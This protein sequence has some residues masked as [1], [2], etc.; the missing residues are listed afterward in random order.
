MKRELVVVAVVVALTAGCVGQQQAVDPART[1]RDAGAAMAKL[2]TVTATLKFTKEPITFQGFTLVGARTSVRL[3]ADSDTIYTVK[4]QDFTISLEVIISGG[5]VY[6]HVPFSTFQEL[7]GSEAAA[8]PDLAKLFDPSGGL[9]S[10]IP[11]GRNLRSAGADKVGDVDVQKIDATYSGAQV[12]GMLPQLSSNVD[13][14]AELWVGSSDH[15][16]RKAV[17][18]GAFGDGGKQSSVEVNISGFNATVN[19]T[20]PSP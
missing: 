3:P 19:I 13:V 11:S 17:L 15:L 10:V 5:H 20:P 6:L 7:T 9:P 1:L 8:V 2:Q 18:D 16:I 4:Q 14:N 12:S